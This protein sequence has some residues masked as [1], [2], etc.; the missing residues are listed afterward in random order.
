MF[1]RSVALGSSKPALAI[2]SIMYFSALRSE[3]EILMSPRVN[4]LMA[5]NYA[6]LPVHL[7]LNVISRRHPRESG[8]PVLSSDPQEPKHWIPAFA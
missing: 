2:F 7:A 8:D 3:V 5:A 4:R 6:G 1:Y